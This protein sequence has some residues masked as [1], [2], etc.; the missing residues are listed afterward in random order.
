M[1]AKENIYP[2]VREMALELS[3]ED[4]PTVD[5]NGVRFE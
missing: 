5:F 3:F 4:L 2:E 1:S